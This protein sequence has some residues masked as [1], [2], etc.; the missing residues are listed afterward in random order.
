M[1]IKMSFEAILDQDVEKKAKSKKSYKLSLNELNTALETDSLLLEKRGIP[2]LDDVLELITVGNRSRRL[3]NLGGFTGPIRSA[4]ATDLINVGLGDDADTI[5]DVIMD[6]SDPRFAGVQK[7]VRQALELANNSN[8]GSVLKVGESAGDDVYFLI[9]MTDEGPGIIGV[10]KGTSPKALMDEASLLIAKRFL[11]NP[12]LIATSDDAIRISRGP[13]L[14]VDEY[15][16][17]AR[18]FEDLA[19]DGVLSPDDMQTLMGRLQVRLNP[20]RAVDPATLN[21]ADEVNDALRQIDAQIDAGIST[22]DDLN[23]YRNSLLSRLDTLGDDVVDTADD[24]VGLGAKIARGVSSVVNAIKRYFTSFS[25]G[26]MSKLDEN[27]VFVINADTYRA[28]DGTIDAQRIADELPDLPDGVNIN[29][30]GVTKSATESAGL[31]YVGGLKGSNVDASSRA[32]ANFAEAEGLEEA[33]IPATVNGK[34]V[35]LD[36]DKADLPKIAVWRKGQVVFEEFASESVLLQKF[37]N[38]VDTLNLPTKGGWGTWRVLKMFFTK[39]IDWYFDPLEPS[40]AKRAIYG[41]LRLAGDL[42]G[43]SPTRLA[44]Q[45][46]GTIPLR[47]VLSFISQKVLG[48]KAKSINIAK[49]LSSPK[50]WKKFSTWATVLGVIQVLIEELELAKAEKGSKLFKYKSREHIELQEKIKDATDLKALSLDTATKDTE[51]IANINKLLDQARVASEFDLEKEDREEIPTVNSLK[52]EKLRIARRASLA[53]L[54][55]IIA[56]EK[57]VTARLNDALK[58]LRIGEKSILQHLVKQNV[59][60]ERFKIT[61][62]VDN[63]EAEKALEHIENMSAVESF[64]DGDE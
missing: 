4:K 47:F 19:D 63:P 12:N 48:P 22:A 45:T 14:T 55:K 39:N 33:I 8:V 59:K 34:I 18:R 10:A 58:E 2:F 57:A 42:A 51:K 5:I 20:G 52:G 35:L 13:A 24:T 49:L 16:K 40:K 46:M 30:I 15:D 29:G 64:E 37:D 50:N 53:N 54:D 32:M 1:K 60:Y 27:D 36:A 38:I 56:L 6:A 43:G 44:I 23:V 11:D 28:T 41:L 31:A 9:G 25:N 21:S 26:F 7:E 17:L 61:G 62:P 3:R